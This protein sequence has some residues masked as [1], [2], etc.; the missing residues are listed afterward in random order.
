[1]SSN[2][3][4]PNISGLSI[5]N[6][7]NKELINDLDC[8][9]DDLGNEFAPI[10]LEELH[11]RLEF[12]INNFNNELNQLIKKSFKSHHTIYNQLDTMISTKKN[13]SLVANKNNIKKIEIDDSVP[14]YLQGLGLE[15]EK[16]TR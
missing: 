1:M 8:I 11:N 14:S 12:I 7:A 15:N 5:L 4:F 3:N 2:S 6:E 13:I 9:I 10:I 16:H